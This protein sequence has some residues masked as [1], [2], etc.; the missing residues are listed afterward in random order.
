MPPFY[1]PP[2][3]EEQIAQLESNSPFDGLMLFFM[4][5]SKR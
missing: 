1:L 5:V 3:A 4:H 2:D